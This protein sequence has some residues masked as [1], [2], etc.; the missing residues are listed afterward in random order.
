MLDFNLRIQIQN[1]IYQEDGK[2]ASK[3]RNKGNRRKRVKSLN[4]LT[5]EFNY[6]IDS[7]F[8]KIEMERKNKEWNSTCCPVK[9]AFKEAVKVSPKSSPNVKMVKNSLKK[10]KTKKRTRKGKKK[11]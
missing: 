8:K 1:K 3:H 6:R 10:T 11:K 4:S 5:W 7:I 9:E 2:M